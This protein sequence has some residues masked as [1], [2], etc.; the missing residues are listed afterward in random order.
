MDYETFEYQP[1]C[2]VPGCGRPAVYKVAAPWTF[3]S[4]AELK[5]YGTCCADHRDTL[6]ERARAM[7]AQC[8]A[9]AGETIG[10]VG[11]YQILPGLRDRDLS[12]V[13]G[14]TS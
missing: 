6:F 3:G 5:N 13:S 8:R 4:F 10:P 2:S 12:M 7:H 11:V 9:A 14:A 1:R